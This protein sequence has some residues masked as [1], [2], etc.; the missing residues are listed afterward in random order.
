MQG[1]IQVSDVRELGEWQML[2]IWR[3]DLKPLSQKGERYAEL[4]TSDQACYVILQVWSALSP[5]LVIL[6]EAGY[7]VT[8]VQEG[9]ILR[10]VGWPSLWFR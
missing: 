7:D 3:S 1:E 5:V 10:V 9:G 8:N 2:S 6:E 4:R